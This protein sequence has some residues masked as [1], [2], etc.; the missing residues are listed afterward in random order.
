MI[1]LDTNVVSET[2]KL[3]PEPLVVNW[4][5]RQARETLYLTAVSLSELLFGI[6]LLDEGRRKREM[7]RAVQQLLDERFVARVL[8]FDTVCAATYANLMSRARHR[9][10]AIAISDGQIAAIAKAHGFAV[11]TRDRGPF[12]AAG[13]KVIDPWVA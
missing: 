1:V 8:P 10:L 4:L 6:E 2:I 3:R 13:L 9:G 12:E 5:N 11:A 7:A